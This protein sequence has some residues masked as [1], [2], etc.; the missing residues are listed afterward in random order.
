MRLR[1]ARGVVLRL[2][3]ARL[4]A[5]IAGATLVAVAA[6][7]AVFEMPWESWWTDGLGL[8]LG[9]TGGAM[10]LFSVAARRPDWV[11]PH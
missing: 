7:L 10:F 1:R 2:V 11:D 4:S 5:A 9:G 6:A 8:V 3:Q